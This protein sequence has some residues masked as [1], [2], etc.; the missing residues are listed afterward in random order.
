MTII[1][2]PG[3]YIQR[4][5]EVVS[6]YGIRDGIAYIS[7]E[8]YYGMIIGHQAGRFDQEESPYD[9]VGKVASDLADGN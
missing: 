1:D 2:R 7:M 6:I 5:G 8:G 3:K 4:N 9:I